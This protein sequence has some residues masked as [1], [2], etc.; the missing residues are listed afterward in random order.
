MV[1][2]NVQMTENPQKTVPNLGTVTAVP[3]LPQCHS[4]DEMAALSGASHCYSFQLIA[5]MM[6]A[7]P[8]FSSCLQVLQ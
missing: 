3:K 7:S 4:P 5:A 6:G 1:F 2:E 8:C